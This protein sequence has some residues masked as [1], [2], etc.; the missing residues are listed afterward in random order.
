M[1]TL[2][3][4]VS[5]VLKAV[6]VVA[7][8]MATWAPV[9]SAQPAPS[10][11]SPA[12]TPGRWTVTPFIGFAFSGDV[13]SATGAF[14]VAGAYNWDA[15]GLARRRVRALPSGESDGAL[16]VDSNLVSFT[17]NVLYHFA[18]RPLAPYAVF[19]IGFGHSSVDL[20]SDDPLIGNLVDTSSTASSR[21]SVA[22]SSA[23]SETAWGFVAISAIFSAATSF[24]TIGG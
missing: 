3:V 22:A 13:D 12:L 1:T 7:L 14:G 23:V 6:G 9:A 8:A 2:S 11:E 20:D 21:I 16:E 17:G 19:G 18:N 5:R 10:A 24:R 4:D 15:A